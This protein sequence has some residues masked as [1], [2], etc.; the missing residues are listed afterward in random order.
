M[1]GKGNYYQQIRP[2]YIIPSK[3]AKLNLLSSFHKNF[4]VLW[5]KK[6]LLAERYSQNLK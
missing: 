2:N 6:D 4:L 5:L 1:K 3:I